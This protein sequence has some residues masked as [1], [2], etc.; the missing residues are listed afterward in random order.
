VCHDPERQPGV[1]NLL[2]ILA[3]CRRV[4]PGETAAVV[5]SYSELKEAVVDEVLAVVRP[6]QHRYA[7]VRSEMSY[8]TGILAEGAERARHRTAPTLRGAYAAIGLRPAA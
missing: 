1:A 2:E 5:S 3:A 6:I 8:L 7:E 4:T